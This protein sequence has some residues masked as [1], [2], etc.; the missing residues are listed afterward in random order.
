[1]NP[2]VQRVI[3]ACE[4]LVSEYS[5]YGEVLQQDDDGGYGAESAIGEAAAAI[6]AL[7]PGRFKLTETGSP[8]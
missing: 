1:M 3:D 2:N 7:I 4:R 6:N 5:V 8:L